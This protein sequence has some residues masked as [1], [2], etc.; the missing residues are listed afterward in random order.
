MAVPAVKLLYHLCFYVSFYS[1]HSDALSITFLSFSTISD[2]DFNTANQ[3]TK[4]KIF[5]LLQ[6]YGFSSTLPLSLYLFR[7]CRS[8]TLF[9][10]K[11]ISTKMV[12]RL[13]GHSCWMMHK[14]FSHCARKRENFERWK[15]N[16]KK[17]S[18]E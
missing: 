3:S 7:S 6:S 16:E 4:T 11:F 13:G 2:E 12:I 5:H 9:S 15:T 8:Q 10:I 1:F 18:I 14:P 17:I